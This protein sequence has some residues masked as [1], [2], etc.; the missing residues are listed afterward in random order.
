MWCWVTFAYVIPAIGITIQILAP[1][2]HRLLWSNA[3]I[4]KSGSAGDQ[5][6]LRHGILLCHADLTR[7]APSRGGGALVFPELEGELLPRAPCDDAIS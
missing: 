5:P 3:T 2:G 7:G 4:R 1:G 6:D